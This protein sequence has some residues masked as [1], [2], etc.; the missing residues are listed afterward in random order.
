[1]KS[2]L[3]SVAFILF[4]FC[5]CQAQ[6]VLYFPQFVDGSEGDGDVERIRLCNRRHRAK[7]TGRLYRESPARVATEHRRA[8]ARRKR[9]VAGVGDPAGCHCH[10]SEGTDRSNQR[11]I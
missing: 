11:C 3:W 1:M 9:G 4:A 8:K 5:I 2:I 7:G 6:S 10:K